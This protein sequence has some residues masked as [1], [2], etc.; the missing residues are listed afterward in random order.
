MPDFGF[1]AQPRQAIIASLIS[2]L[3]RDSDDARIETVTGRYADVT[4]K[5]DGRISEVLQIEKTIRDIQSYGEAVALTEARAGAMQTALNQITDTAQLIVDQADLL[6]TNGT[7]QNLQTLSFQARDALDSVVSALNLDFGGRALFAGD[8]AGGVALANSTEIF[9]DATAALE[10]QSGAA[11]AFAN[12]STE[13]LGTAGVFETNHYRGGAGAAPLSDIGPGERV[14]Y[15]VKADEIPL[16]RTIMGLAA[17]AAA[18]DVGN[19]IPQDQRQGILDQAAAELR[20]GIGG[21]IGI[22]GRLGTAEAR[23]ADVK[24]RN[25][26]TEATLTLAYNEMTSADAY[27]SALRLTEFEDQLET[28]F[29]TTARLARLSLSEYF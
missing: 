5:L 19:A 24:A 26:A 9:A 4:M 18:F 8:D 3:R 13:F 22:Q 17:I 2:G 28:A 20:S 14:S 29:A 25:S 10:G 21:T 7:D 6:R 1:P 16:R 15:S 11:A 23:I 27:T 12:L